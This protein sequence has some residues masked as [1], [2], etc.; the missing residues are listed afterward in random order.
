MAQETKLSKKLPE[1]LEAEI[2]VF[3][4]GLP[5]WSKYM[6]EKWL[7]G[8]VISEE[9]T[10]AAYFFLLEE[11]G[12]KTK[13][14]RQ[15]LVI[16]YDVQ[17]SGN[18]KSDLLFAKVQNVEGV[19]AL[20][21]GQ[22]IEFGNHLTIIYG[23]NGSGKSG[24]TRLFKLVFY[25]KS[26]EEILKNIHID[27]GHKAV[28]AN[29]SFTSGTDSISLTLNDKGKAEFTQFSVFDGKSVIR[30]L[31]QRNEFEFRPAALLSLLIIPLRL[32]W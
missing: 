11:L 19:N 22:T 9:V 15:T 10:T 5:Y 12:L 4:D 27:T 14:E 28:S 26:K 3:A 21:E 18:H 29:F 32:Q 7:S 17:K 16:K 20:M 30:H 1:T 24:Y 2:K 8:S 31:D 6:A 23:A 13:S 25:S